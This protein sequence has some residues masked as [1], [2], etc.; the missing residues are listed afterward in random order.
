MRPGCD[1]L[2]G[3]MAVLALAAVAADPPAQAQGLPAG[4]AWSLRLGLEEGFD[5]NVRF[6]RSDS[7]DAAVESDFVT[8]LRAS[9]S[10]TRSGDRGRLTWS[11]DGSGFTYA[12]NSDL[13]GFS[14]GASL[15]GDYSF[16]PRFGATLSEGFETGYARD[17]RALVDDGLLLPRVRTDRNDAS[18]VL[19]LGAS[20]RVSLLGEVRH[21]W[22]R[23]DSNALTDDTQLRARLVANRALT[24][25]HKLGLTLSYSLLRADTGGDSTAGGA[26]TETYSAMAGWSGSLSPRWGGHISLGAILI[27]PEGAESVVTPAVEAGLTG[28][29]ERGTVEANYN[30]EVRSAFGFG[31]SRV[32][33]R[34][35]LAINR[36]VGVRTRFT[37]SVV[38]AFGGDPADPDFDIETLGAS[39]GLSRPLGRRWAIGS[40][41]TYARQS[42]SGAPPRYNHS[43]DG[44]L[45]FLHF[46]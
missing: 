3:A 4:A 6:G 19:R 40:S 45:R 5:S 30:R 42:V 9:L 24:A 32:L 39:A 7:V 1:P 35:S 16:S 46:W 28:R 38:Y 21:E 17:L 13:N 8:R 26:R 20:N 44:F 34:L 33:N 12:R 37:S 36:A 23:F 14:A 41:Y 27:E 15:A 18:A 10:R 2:R 25:S 43:V 29:M 22:V 11:L 31:R